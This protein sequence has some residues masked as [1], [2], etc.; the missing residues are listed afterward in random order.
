MRHQSA[1]AATAEKE[2]IR[3]DFINKQQ[4]AE[5]SAFF[6]NL[7]VIFWKQTI[8]PNRSLSDREYCRL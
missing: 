6:A 3:F 8:K 2:I 4:T 5:L 7:R 1:A